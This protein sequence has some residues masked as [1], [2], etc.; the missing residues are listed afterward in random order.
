[1]IHSQLQNSLK[2]QFWNVEKTLLNNHLRLSSSFL[3]EPTLL[4]L[5]MATVDDN[6][7]RKKKTIIA[8]V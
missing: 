7:N 4:I 6:I 2:E 5:N 8:P 3:N 1:M